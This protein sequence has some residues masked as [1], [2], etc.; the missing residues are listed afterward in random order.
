MNYFQG[1]IRR[2]RAMRHTDA[3]QHHRA[4]PGTKITQH[5]HPTKITEHRARP[6]PK[7]QAKS[8]TYESL[9]ELQRMSTT[10]SSRVRYD[11]PDASAENS[12][13]WERIFGNSAAATKP[14]DVSGDGG[15]NPITIKSHEELLAVFN[16]DVASLQS[17]DD[18]KDAYHKVA[19]WSCI[20]GYCEA[21]TTHKDSSRRYNVFPIPM[22]SLI[23]LVNDEF[24]PLINQVNDQ[25]NNV[26]SDQCDDN[27]HRQT[28]QSL[29]NAIWK[30]CQNKSSS[31][32]DELHANSLYICLC[33]DV[34][35]K[36]LDCFGAALT[37]V[38]GMNLLGYTS[39]LTL[40]E[41]HAYESHFLG[42]DYATCEV[43]I[44][45][46]TKASQSK[47]G[48]EISETFIDLQKQSPRQ[49][50]RKNITAETSW[51]YMKDNAVLCDTAGM[52]LAALVGNMNCDIDKQKPVGESS[53]KPHVVSGTLYKMKR[54]MLWVLY[55]ARCI[56]NFPF[57]MMELGECEEHL[58]T[59]R[60]LEWVDA[61]EMLRNEKNDDTPN[62]D[63]TMVLQNEYF[64]L[65]SISTSKKNYKDAQV[66]PYL[67]AAHYHRDAG[68]EDE[69]QDYRLAESMRLYSEAT[70]VASQYRYDAKDCLQLMKHMTTV[71]SLIA[72]DILL[73]PKEAGGDGKVARRWKSR[74]NAVAVTTWLIG[75]F[76]SLLLW[77]E[78][79]EN[80][81]VEIL[82][83]QHKHAIGKLF[84]LLPEDIRV[85]A[86]EKISSQEKEQRTKLNAITEDELI[87]FKHPRSKRLSKDSLLLQ[88][89]MK[90]KVVI[91]EMEMA[92]PC[93]SS[94]ERSTRQRKR[95]KT[96]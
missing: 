94:G 1:N 63:E 31:M 48:R 52:A 39:I 35:G 16:Q 19:I 45:G 2:K 4:E 29:S 65:S 53:G 11:Y 8:K 95:P 87:Y 57:A 42:N 80:Q 67:Y 5:Q 40:S 58:S 38:V 84:Q 22:A 74:E 59:A 96:Q 93:I 44:P 77:E 30:R 46:N 37:T 14:T 32:Q 72:K 55:D 91:R 90:K 85:T 86:M 81:F 27:N 66:Y 7:A 79:E 54:D 61:S 89:L 28:V 21:L 75:F 78:N 51:L 83:T 26:L 12:P 76:D 36:S 20:I 6:K 92:L 70:R 43:A 13:H 23:R 9:E 3:I 69:S 82:S 34:D 56:E 73:L 17:S 71:A 49:Q 24:L 62:A 60:G 10:K 33:G 25:N 88:A 47:R 64:F 15:G 41:D 50:S 18:R 68:R